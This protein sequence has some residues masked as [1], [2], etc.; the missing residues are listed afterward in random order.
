MS[1]KIYAELDNHLLD[2]PDEKELKSFIDNLVYRDEPAMRTISSRYSLIK[3]YL[4]KNYDGLELEFLST[5][6]PP[7]EIIKA[8]L[9]EDSEKRQAKSNFNF[10]NKD[11]ELILDLKDSDNS[12]DQAIYLQFVSGRRASEIYQSKDDHELIQL[13][14]VKNKPE[15]VKFSTLHKKN[16]DKIELVKLIP[17]TIDSKEF[18]KMYLKLRKDLNE[19]STQDSINRM[20]TRL[21][22]LFPQ[23]KLMSSHKLRGM[24]ASY[25]FNKFNEEDQNINGFITD[26]LNH[27]STDAS[28]SYSNYKYSEIK[29]PKPDRKI[30]KKE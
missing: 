8:L 13:T 11:V 22:K 10:N 12:Q 1:K 30:K 18:K 4:K 29:Q 2:D 3:T 14:R 6:K 23:N 25:M 20:N 9:N 7:E 24:Y 16:N 17:D 19:I 15:I 28:M 21:K 27:S 26:I 5:I